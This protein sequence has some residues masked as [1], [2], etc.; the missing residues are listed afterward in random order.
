ML[1]RHLIRSI[2]ELM[3]LALTPSFLTGVLVNFPEAGGLCGICISQKGVVSWR[4]FCVGTAKLLSDRPW[5]VFWAGL[6]TY[7][8]L[9]QGPLHLLS[10]MVLKTKGWPQITVERHSSDYYPLFNTLIQVPTNLQSSNKKK[11]KKKK[12]R[13]KR[14]KVTHIHIL[15]MC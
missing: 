9:I 12:E 13:K 3:I 4:E 15:Q 5:P 2:F 6:R 8:L 7:H 14:K 11:K 1:C 10:G